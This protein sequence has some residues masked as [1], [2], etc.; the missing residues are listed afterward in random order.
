MRSN[1]LL[2]MPRAISAGL[3]THDSPSMSFPS[4]SVMVIFSVRDVVLVFKH[5]TIFVES[6]VPRG[7]CATSSSYL[8]L[9]FSLC[10]VST[11]LET[12]IEYLTRS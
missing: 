5:Y 8:A 7:F 10:L 11:G 12:A 6:N 1:R 3:V 2:L 9:S 4:P